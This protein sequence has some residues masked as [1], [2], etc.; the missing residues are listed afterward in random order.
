M[1]DNDASYLPSKQEKRA[2]RLEALHARRGKVVAYVEERESGV[3]TEGVDANGGKL[4]PA[5][6]EEVEK[7]RNAIDAY[8]AECDSAEIVV[9]VGGRGDTIT[10]SR[11]YTMAGLTL[12]LGLNSADQLKE[13]RAVPGFAEL[14]GRALLKMEKQRNEDLLVTA[15]NPAGII[16]DLKNTFRWSE[17]PDRKRIGVEITLEE[18]LAEIAGK[19]RGLPREKMETAELIEKKAKRLKG[20]GKRSAKK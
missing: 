16:F 15:G 6:A 1:S 17:Q 12:A 2:Q 7:L 13:L 5:S 19:S 14:L 18:A 9:K 3:V 11:P 4:A 8:F 20:H 10:K